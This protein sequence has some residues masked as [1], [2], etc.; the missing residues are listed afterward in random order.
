M[1]FC[2]KAFGVYLGGTLASPHF[3][4]SQALEVQCS[5]L[6]DPMKWPLSRPNRRSP[7]RSGEL[8]ALKKPRHHA[9]QLGSSR[10]PT[11]LSWT[12]GT[13]HF[14]MKLSYFWILLSRSLF[15]RHIYCWKPM[16][17]SYNV[18]HFYSLCF[19]RS[20]HIATQTDR[21]C[22][23]LNFQWKEI[24]EILSYFNRRYYKRE[25]YLHLLLRRHGRWPRPTA[26]LR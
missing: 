21:F 19:P 3:L 12:A 18:K 11:T 22:T 14:P 15:Y 2:R 13:I 4:R 26:T 10:D 7:I 6:L 23:L 20:R 8:E 1:Y 9:S 16:S 24:L 17:F 5:Y 25:S